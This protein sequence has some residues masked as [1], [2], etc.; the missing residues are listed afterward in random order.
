MD[1]IERETHPAFGWA[2]VNTVHGGDGSL[3][4]S[5]IKHQHYVVLRISHADRKR[6]LHRD[7]IHERGRIVEVAMSMAQW[8]ALVS[9]F[10]SSGVPV[11]L[12]W[13]EGD[14]IEP[15]PY[16]PRMEHSVSEVADASDRVFGSV[17]DAIKELREVFD[18]K[19]GRRDMAAALRNAEIRLGNAKSNL[20]FAA[21]S[22]TEHVENVV[23]KAR[24][25]IEAAVQMA[26]ERGLDAGDPIA[27]LLGAAPAD[28]PVES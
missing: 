13:A 28:P 20:T 8:G 11:T 26:A 15:P 2:Q 17:A 25:D 24:Y 3:F 10:G 27:G 5:E 21:D 22:L 16:A 18:A 4:D 23:T 14:R 1:E 6:D 9:S 7:W 12:T 19:G